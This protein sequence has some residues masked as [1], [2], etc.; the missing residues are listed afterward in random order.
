MTSANLIG[1]LVPVRGAPFPARSPMALCGWSLVAPN[2]ISKGVPALLLVTIRSLTVTAKVTE[3]ISRV[4][5][6]SFI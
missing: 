4:I 6:R 2:Q 5:R 1:A 3:L